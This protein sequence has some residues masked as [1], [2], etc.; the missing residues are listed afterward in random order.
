MSSGQPD[1]SSRVLLLE[2][3]ATCADMLRR[4]LER[5]GF[6]VECAS[7]G[8]EA[9]TLSGRFRPHVVLLNWSLPALS[10][11][12]VCRR[13]R[14]LPETRDAGVIMTGRAGDWRVGS[15]P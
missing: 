4:N 14:A 13:L 7:N 10:G 15:R 8:D 12:K 1:L 6:V 11:I 5:N 2:G 3:R 9:L